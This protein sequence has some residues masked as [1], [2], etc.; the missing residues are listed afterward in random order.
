M[1]K[2]QDSV[3]AVKEDGSLIGWGFGGGPPASATPAT[4]IVGGGYH[5]IV[6][7]PD[8][9]LISWAVQGGEFYE[10]PTGPFVEMRACAF[11]SAARRADGSLAVW[12]RKASEILPPAGRVYS[13]L[14]IG[15]GI[16]PGG[17]NSED[18]PY[19]AAIEIDQDSDGDQVIDWA[20]N[21]PTTPNPNQ[22]DCDMD[23]VGDVC[24]SISPYPSAQEW[25][26]AGG[27]NGHWY[28][29]FDSSITWDEAKAACEQLGGYLA[30][31][32]SAEEDQ[33]V[34]GIN[35]GTDCWIGGY[36]VPQSCEPACGWTWVSGEPWVY[37]NWLPSEPSN[38][39]PEE[40]R[41]SYWLQSSG[42]NDHTTIHTGPY[43]CEWNTGIQPFDCNANSIP[44]SC[45]IASGGSL[46]LDGDGVPD[47]CSLDC[48]GDGVSNSEEIALG[49]EADCDGN[50]IPDSCENGTLTGTTG[51]MGAFGVGAAATGALSGCQ[52]STTDVS[53]QLEVVGDL[54]AP[55][56]FITLSIGGAWT[57]PN[58]FVTSGTD[59]PS[60]PNTAV[61]TIPVDQ[62]NAMVASSGA[63]ELTVTISAAPLVDAAQC[64][65][66]SSMVS[67]TYGGPAFDCNG[68]GV[69]DHCQ[70]ADGGQDCNVNGLLDA[71]EIVDGSVPDV[72]A[73]G[74]PDPCQVDCNKNALPDSWEVDQGLV[75]DCNGNGIPD[76]CDIATGKSL[77]CNG[78]GVPDSCDLASGASSDCNGNGIPD[79][80]DLASGQ[81][82]DC[83]ANSVPDSCDI[84]SGASADVDSNGVPDDCKG[85]CNGN[86][87]P[88]SWELSQGLQPDCDANGVIDSCD[89][90]SGTADD[91]N[92]NGIPDSCDVAD[93]A[94]DKDADGTPDDCE[95][96]LGD[97]DLDGS[98]SGGDLATLFALWGMANP[99]VGD[100]DGDGIVAGGD[101]TLL[102]SRWGEL[103]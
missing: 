71:C 81:S 74:V 29:R 75:L 18:H 16:G 98:I 30:T 95:Y 9:S 79:S 31:P 77:D 60:V 51:E 80:C 89:L 78:N 101:L 2:V 62:W 50:W 26:V 99:P 6:S 97:F 41:L 37:T 36:Q 12:G 42:W 21:C 44:D 65:N 100:L 90:V 15:L 88:D 83:N 96:A 46:D 8:G 73:N 4:A 56:E 54:G 70:I 76:S 91:C 67:V 22:A 10:P 102:L 32:S 72:D 92:G 33:F 7:K 103:P 52:F 43:I 93:G 94:T 13:K 87:L 48:D 49:Y 34:S 23:G 57:Q 17:W 27:G 58:L 55:T 11:T 59:C 84:A 25:A 39:Y 5:F 14:A 86:G 82:Y 64:T 28:A 40:S 63:G 35:A 3:V 85:D 20:D 1:A 61:F 68:D 19:L 38:G 45:E 53:V 24:D 69:S 66:G 47:E